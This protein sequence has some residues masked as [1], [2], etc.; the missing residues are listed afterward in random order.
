M[1][2]DRVSCSKLAA[3]IPLLTMAVIPLALTD[4]PWTIV[5]FFLDNPER[6]Q[7]RCTSPEV[8]Q[9]G[10][11][12]RLVVKAKIEILNGNQN[13]ERDMQSN[14]VYDQLSG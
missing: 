2:Q 8:Q 9:I 7:M 3:V 6:G 13:Q 11:N 14:L 5:L 12:A 10:E 1:A 4:A